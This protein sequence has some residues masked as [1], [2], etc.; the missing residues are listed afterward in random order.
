[1][2]ALAAYT[3]ARR[4]EL[5]RSQHQDIHLV[6]G[7]LLLR[8]KK[9][10]RSK[11]TFR[12]VPIADSLAPILSDWLKH[13]TEGQATF[14][15]TWPSNRKLVLPE[16]EGG[17]LPAEAH[18]HLQQ[19]LRESKWSV[20]PGWH[21]FRHSFISN[22][23]SQGVDQ[24]MIDD[25]VGHQTDEQRKRYRHLFPDVQKKVLDKVF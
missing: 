15:R 14:L 24:R 16:I 12:Q 10:N 6:P 13:R 21:V 22:C 8:E 19:A 17:V 25:W 18:N 7:N 4:S 5:C 1:M 20:V 2:A 23:A 11:R 3:G 9:R